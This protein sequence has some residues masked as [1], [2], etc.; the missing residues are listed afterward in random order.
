MNGNHEHHS[1]NIVHP[2][3]DGCPPGDQCR[4]TKQEVIETSTE[5]TKVKA[6][7]M[8]GESPTFQDL[9]DYLKKNMCFAVYNIAA[10]CPKRKE[11]KCRERPCPM[12]VMTCQGDL[13]ITE[14]WCKENNIDF[15]SLRP[16]VQING[17]HC[18]CEILFNV[19]PEDEGTGIGPNICLPLIEET[20][21]PE[22]TE[23]GTQE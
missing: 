8:K 11:N 12:G 7:T 16:L 1:Q 14:Q 18:D 19:M 3:N 15:S 22:T 4:R 21:E 5:E 6:Q 13:S 23:K 17:G 2:V 10:K 20:T 9:Y